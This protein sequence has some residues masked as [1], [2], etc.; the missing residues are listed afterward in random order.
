MVRGILN[1]IFSMA[2]RMVNRGKVVVTLGDRSKL[3]LH[4]VHG[5]RGN[6]LTVGNDSLIGSRVAFDRVGAYIEI[7]DRCYIGASSL[8]SAESII[9]GDDVVISWGVTIVD[10]NSHDAAWEGREGDILNWAKGLKNW[11]YVIRAP[12]RIEDRVW[13]GFNAIILKGVTIGSGAVVAAGSVVTRDVEPNT[14][15]AGNP[16]RFVRQI[17]QSYNAESLQSDD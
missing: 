14:I 5:A 6:R 9:L 11:E 8:V 16:A 12:V 4:K 3:Q 13:I 17:E 1:T 2:W 10:H 7:G 15:V